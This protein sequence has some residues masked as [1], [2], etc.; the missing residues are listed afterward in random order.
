[1]RAV[2]LLGGIET[3]GAD[4]AKDAAGKLWEAGVIVRQLGPTLAL[5]PPLI[6]SEAEV[7]TA[8]AALHDSLLGGSEGGGLGSAT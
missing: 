7:E 1:V 2:G 8:A 3:V 4:V 5:S 6:V